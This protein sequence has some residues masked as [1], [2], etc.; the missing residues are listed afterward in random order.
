MEETTVKVKLWGMVLLVVAALG[1]L[2]ISS[3]AME[4]RIT[5]NETS[6][7]YIISSITEVKDLV[8]EIRQDQI[9]RHKR[10]NGR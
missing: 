6:I 2:Y 10:E 7:T 1:F 5:R 8:K 4:S 3:T 9:S